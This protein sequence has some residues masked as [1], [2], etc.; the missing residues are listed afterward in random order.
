MKF[1]T[2]AE[3]LLRN[4]LATLPEPS[5]TFQ[6]GDAVKVVGCKAFAGHRGF[7]RRYFSG[8][9]DAVGEPRHIWSVELEGVKGCLSFG[10]R[11]LQLVPGN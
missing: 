8:F 11:E 6:P 10:E 2:S 4:V 9:F 3:D 5:S 1:T 7:V